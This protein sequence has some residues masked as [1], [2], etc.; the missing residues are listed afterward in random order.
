LAVKVGKSEDYFLRP[1]SWTQR[2]GVLAFVN[3][4]KTRVTWGGPKLAYVKF[5]RPR[6]GDELAIGYPLIE[7]TQTIGIWPSRPDLKF[8][9]TWRGNTAIDIDPKGKYLPIK[10]TSEKRSKI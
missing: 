1:P 9:I 6:I 3:G 5:E 4:R 7:F 8:K 2:D 10:T